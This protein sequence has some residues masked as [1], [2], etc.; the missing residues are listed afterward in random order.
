MSD[1]AIRL[2]EALSGVDEELLERSNRKAGGK[3]TNVRRLFWRNGRAMAA[4]ICLI[5]VGAAA[6]SGYRLVTGPCGA[7]SSQFN[8]APGEFYGMAKDV[9]EWGWGA[10]GGTETNDVSALEPAAGTTENE[11]K[12]EIAPD[13]NA[14][15]VGTMDD[16]ST[17]AAEQ[18]AMQDMQCQVS[19]SMTYSTECQGSSS[20]MQSAGK[21]DETDRFR[22]NMLGL[23]EKENGLTD[24]RQEVSWEEASAVQPFA[25]Y[26]PSVL[27]GEYDPLSVRRS[28]DIDAWDNMIFIWSNG[29]EIFT[30]NMTQGQ[31]LTEEEIEKR[32]GL[33]QYPAES[34]RE[35]MIPE[36]LDG[37]ITF[38]LYYADGMQIDFAGCVTAGEMWEVVESVGK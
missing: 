9:A 28:V 15:G 34:F 12:A 11:L 23:Y 19:A 16:V 21:T 8:Q 37:R 5:V 31:A 26:V 14:A 10:A 4:C 7:D 1:Q 6:W 3:A 29:E 20:D 18:E 27:P 24:S 35:D 30:L 25:A 32:D 13:G 22:E 38:T 2:F 36:P 17:A 33:Y